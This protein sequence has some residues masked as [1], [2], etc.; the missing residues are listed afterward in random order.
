MFLMCIVVEKQC[1]F[2]GLSH[3]QYGTSTK[4]GFF[5]KRVGR[6]PSKDFFDKG[7]LIQDKSCAAVIKYTAD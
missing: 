3:Q 5:F 7:R 6:V 4:I 2:F 1:I